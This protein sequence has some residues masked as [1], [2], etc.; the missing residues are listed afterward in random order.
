VG[1]YWEGIDRYVRN[2]SAEVQL[3]ETDWA[4]RVHDLGAADGKEK[5]IGLFR[6][7]DLGDLLRVPGLLVRERVPGR[8]RGA[9]AT[10][11]SVN[12]C[13]PGWTG[14][15]GY[16]EGHGGCSTGNGT[17]ALCFAWRSILT[18]KQN[19]L[20]VNFLLNRASPWDDVEGHLPYM[21]T[22]DIRIKQPN[23]LLVRSPEWVATCSGLT[24]AR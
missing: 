5:G 1:D 19:T 6:P 22:V 16:R 10:H 3:P 13:Y 7:D 4:Y 18:H 24:T 14:A 2:H 8:I 9:F 20:R 11:A 23:R 17:R 15:K 21:G 12:D